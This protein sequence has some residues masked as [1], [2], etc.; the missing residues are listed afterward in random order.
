MGPM[1]GQALDQLSGDAFDRAFLQEMIMHHAMAIGMAQPVAASASHQEA[2]DLA[3]AIIVDQAREIDQMR[4]WLKDWY[5]V[6]MPDPAGMM[7]GQPQGPMMGQPGQAGPMGPG[8]GPM[9]GQPG[10]AGPMG[11]GDGPMTGQPGPMGP[12]AGQGMG[13]MGGMGMMADLWKLPP[14]RLEA[15]FMSLMIPHHQGAI[16]MANLAP[17]RASHQELK[18]LASSIIQ[19]QTAEI[20]QMNGWLA[21]WYGL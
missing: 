20:G 15:V 19:S 16:D 8:H 21:A 18:D 5:G 11:P 9:T 2:K 17:E 1:G 10:Q 4:T 13:P 12:G 14:N 6:E 7:G 3:N